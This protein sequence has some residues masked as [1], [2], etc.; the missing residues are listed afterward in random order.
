MSRSLFP[1]VLNV[2]L[3]EGEQVTV[4]DTGGREPFILANESV[5]LRGL[6]LRSWSNQI[7]IRFRRDQEDK[8][9]SIQ[10]HYQGKPVGPRCSAILS[11]RFTNSR[12]LANSQRL[13]PATA[14]LGCL[15]KQPDNMSLLCDGS[16]NCI[17]VNVKL[18][19]VLVLWEKQQLCFLVSIPAF[20]YE[21]QL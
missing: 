14:L 17:C 12:F 18:V 13:V 16:S 5:L 6:V 11:I 9:G 1:Q 8:F 3:M 2:S 21:V 7:S 19:D 4:E 15:R 10:L 20:G